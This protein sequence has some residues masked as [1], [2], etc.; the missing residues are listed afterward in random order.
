MADEALGV[1][2]FLKWV[3]VNGRFFYRSAVER[4]DLDV[5]HF[6]ARSYEL[7]ISGEGYAIDAG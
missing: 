4:P 3:G 2:W 6:R 1:D 7:E 5:A